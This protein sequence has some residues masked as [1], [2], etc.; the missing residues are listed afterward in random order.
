MLQIS[1]TGLYCVLNQISI[2]SD[3]VDLQPSSVMAA[4]DK[5]LFQEWR[6]W[7]AGEC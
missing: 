5:R 2:E 1:L 4:L 6:E 7:L 3:S